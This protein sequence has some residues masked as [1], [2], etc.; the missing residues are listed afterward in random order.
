MGKDIEKRIKLF[1]IYVDES[2]DL[3]LAIKRINAILKE[4]NRSEER[5]VLILT[6]E[7]KRPEL[8]E[9]QQ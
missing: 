4:I 7:L 8:E 9:T 3:Y 6:D 2:D 1:E 5:L